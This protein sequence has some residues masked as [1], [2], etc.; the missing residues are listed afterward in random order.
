MI[1][2]DDLKSEV[3]TPG[4]LGPTS[5]SGSAMLARVLERSDAQ[6]FVDS[7][8]DFDVT[9]YLSDCLLVKV[10]IATMACG[11]EGRSPMLDHEF[12]AFAA[13]LP[14]D[15]KLRGTSTKYI[16]KQAAR[17]LVPESIIDRPKKGFSVPLG[18]WF[19][20]E[21]RQL[22]GD[23]LLDGRMAQRG[24]FRP[25]VVE[26]LLNEHWRGDAQW[27]DQLWSLLMLESWHRMFIDARP[28]ARPVAAAPIELPA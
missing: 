14:S 20:G 3:C 8:L 16:L 7:L 15:L 27:E 24:Y 2:D 9:Y 11:L 23:M 10:D 12:M 18:R 5:A 25:R 17:T 28:A 13:G 6:E 4:F 1:F 26:R 22:A 19:R 21:L